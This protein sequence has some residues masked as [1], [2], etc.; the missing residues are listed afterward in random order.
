MKK[1]NQWDWKAS[2]KKICTI[3]KQVKINKLQVRMILRESKRLQSRLKRN[4]INVMV[5]FAYMNVAKT[6]HIQR[7]NARAQ[8]IILPSVR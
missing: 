7:I 2:K 3:R 6:Y 4:K 5:M 1:S 8:H